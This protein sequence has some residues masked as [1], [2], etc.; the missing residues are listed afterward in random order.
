[1][2]SPAWPALLRGSFSGT[3]TRFNLE[4]LLVDSFCCIW[5]SLEEACGPIC[6]GRDSTR[7]VGLKTGGSWAQ[8][9]SC[10]CTDGDGRIHWWKRLS[11]SAFQGEEQARCLCLSH[12][13]VSPEL[14]AGQGPSVGPQNNILVFSLDTEQPLNG[15]EAR[16]PP[17]AATPPAV[18]AP[19]RA[20]FVWGPECKIG[21]SG[22]R[23]HISNFLVFISCAT[24]TTIFNPKCFLPFPSPSCF[25]SEGASPL[26]CLVD[27]ASISSVT[28]KIYL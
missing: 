5:L 22:C 19:H 23:V 12:G 17:S 2:S 8:D 26:F 9:L 10:L 15:R 14:G 25:I 1:M 3:S 4:P 20:A 24:Q 28:V 11:I 13:T 16:V 7:G 18:P 27:F 6:C 21:V